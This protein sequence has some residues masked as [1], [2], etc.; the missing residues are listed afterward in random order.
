MAVGLAVFSHWV[1]DLVTHPM[2]GGPPDLSLLFRGSP[3]VGFGLYSRIGLALATPIELGLIALG[4]AIY[5]SA[6]KRVI[7]Q[8]Q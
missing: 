6:R 8:A 5:R 2:F 7:A 4:Y 1:L 3:R